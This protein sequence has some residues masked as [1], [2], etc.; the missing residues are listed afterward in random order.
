MSY[1]WQDVEKGPSSP[2]QSRREGRKDLGARSVHEVHE[3]DNGP[4]TPLAGFLNILLEGVELALGPGKIH[5]RCI[6]IKQAFNQII[7]GLRH[8]GLCIRDFDVGR[9]TNGKPLAG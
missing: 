6:E 7:T 1:A 2:E 4:R 9:H 5:A 8:R 3:H